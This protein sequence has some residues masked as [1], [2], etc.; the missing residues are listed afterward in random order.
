MDIE[1]K[2]D[3]EFTRINIESKMDI[4]FTR[5][6]INKEE[7]LAYISFVYNNRDDLFDDDVRTLY[8]KYFDCIFKNDKYSDMSSIKMPDIND[9]NFIENWT[10]LLS[11]K[12]ITVHKVS[13]M[14]HTN[15]PRLGYHGPWDY[16]I[17]TPTKMFNERCLYNSGLKRRML[18]IYVYP[19][20]LSRKYKGKDYDFGG[21]LWDEHW[22]EKYRDY[23]L[24]MRDRDI[25]YR[26]HKLLR[27]WKLSK[28]RSK[29]LRRKN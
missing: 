3:I 2:I 28:L 29:I 11:N 21:Y 24:V 20:M 18:D 1:S 8:G 25:Y 4:E 15:Y 27:Y 26:K 10:N 6:I 22:N 9:K 7:F 12:Q 5:T 17:I 13:I 23:D 14:K 19:Y 16:I